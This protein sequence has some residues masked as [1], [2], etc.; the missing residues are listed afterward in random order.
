A[1]DAAADRPRPRRRLCAGV[2]LLGHRADSDAAAAPDQREHA[3]YPV[4]GVHHRT[5]LRRGGAVRGTD[6]G[7]LG[8]PRLPAQPAHEHART[9]AG[10]TVST[11]A[12]KELWKGYADT[13]VLR[14]VNL[15]V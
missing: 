11:L 14:G 13:R 7:D 4:L 9:S 5:L 1:R 10:S 8:G 3:R 6:G 2:H 15:D 12:V